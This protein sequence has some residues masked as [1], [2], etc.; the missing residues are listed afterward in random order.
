MVARIHYE[1]IIPT[2]NQSTIYDISSVNYKFDYINHTMAGVVDLHFLFQT[3]EKHLWTNHWQTS[4]SICWWSKHAPQ[5]KIWCTTSHWSVT[6]VDG[7]RLL[8]WQV[9]FWVMGVSDI[10]ASV[11]PRLY[12]YIY[13][14]LFRHS[15]KNQSMLCTYCYV[16][17]HSMFIFR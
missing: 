2:T 5:G 14:A 4:V 12:R 13:K 7:P 10:L 3:E 11:I 15:S 1:L 6:S 17:S 9:K 8:V 16:V